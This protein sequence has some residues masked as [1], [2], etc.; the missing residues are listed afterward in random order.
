MNDFGILEALSVNVGIVSLMAVLYINLT[1]SFQ[2]KKPLLS[3]ILLG[4]GT[5]MLSML[6]MTFPIKVAPGVILDSRYI[7]IPM[8][9]YFFGLL[10]V[11]IAVLMTCFYRIHLGGVGV[12][13]GIVVVTMVA[14]IGLLF[15][16]YKSLSRVSNVYPLFLVMGLFVGFSTLLG[17]FLLPSE[18]IIET[19]KKIW[20]AVLTAYPVGILV[21]GSLLHAMYTRNRNWED[22]RKATSKLKESE[23]RFRSLAEYSD[24][25]LMR[26]DENCYCLYV[27]PAVKALGID[28]ERI[29]GSRH[30]D[31][32]LPEELIDRLESAINQVFETAKPDRLEFT[33]PQEITYDWML[34]PEFSEDGSVRA[35]IISARDITKRTQLE[36][37]LRESSKTLE[38]RVRKR[39][40]ELEESY[41]QLEEA[42]EKAE[43]ANR[44]KSM[45]LA[46]MSHELRT[47][48]NAILGFSGM[49]AREQNTTA[50]QQDKLTIINRSGEHLL[51]MINEVLDL[52][53]IE[54]GRV[55][56]EA[57]VFDLQR[58]LEDIGRMFEA[59]VKGTGLRFALSLDP[60]LA[61]YVRA[62]AGKLRQILI[63]LLG[64]AVKFTDEGGVTIR[65]ANVPIPEEPTR[66]HIKI[67]VEDT[68]PG[69]DQARQAKIFNPFVQGIDMPVRKGT[70]LGLSICKAYADLMGGTLEVESGLGKGSLFRV[71]LPAEI[72]E[73]ADVK[74]T[75][76][77]K[78]R[79]IGLAPTDKTWRILV[80]D[81]NRDNLLLLKSLLEK[82]GFV[83]LEAKNGKEAVAAFKKESPDFVW[84]DM[85]M[86]V[87][88][89]YEATAKI[90]S[91]PGGDTVKIVAIT[92]SAF[93]EQRSDILAAGCDDVVHKPFKDH[94]I[95][96]T[97]A[98]LLDIK[99]LYEEQAE[100]VTRKDKINLTAEMLAE[101]PPEL[102][103]E[104]RKATLALD[105]EAIFAVIERIEPMSPDTAKGLR[106]LLDNFQTGLISELLGENDEN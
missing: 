23:E 88:D 83:V 74:S 41:K 32:G 8:A 103:Q 79:V 87:M 35:V 1:Q 19:I 95:F 17:S 59:R 69:I 7:I 89:G 36:N 102:L 28:S 93:H 68:G 53:K 34:A 94:K 22:L 73:A 31:I 82:V 50:D 10:P 64:N 39:T 47:P 98:R 30:R 61:R 105:N 71:R 3:G 52:S 58:M 78:P 14:F 43:S 67:E 6:C 5:G 2:E 27:N 15:R 81:D 55:E 57:E 26:F 48:L 84:M 90:R 21:T 70:G 33:S 16:R 99:Y 106:I 11:T 13:A 92:A 29:I 37:Q 9:A 56:L 20:L 65:C 42:K 12:N 75:V 51:S 104:L 97:M 60:E 44:A 40:G 101:L 54:A 25:I 63:N 62:D 96:E 18:M 4:V 86:P 46:N 72:A 49:L 38:D 66:C 76:D 45:F 85:R 91:L 100:E 80:T 24:D 77:D